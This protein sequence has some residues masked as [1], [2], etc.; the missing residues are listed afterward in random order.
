MDDTTNTDRVKSEVDEDQDA[1]Q[2]AH[3]TS[4]VG[5]MEPLL[6][7][8]LPAQF[9][10]CS[11]RNSGKSTLVASL[12][13]QWLKM[14]R[15]DGHSIIVFSATAAHNSE[16]SWLPPENVRHGWDE[17]LC[18]KI[19]QWQKR[20]LALKKKQATRAGIGVKL[21][22][23]ALVL[24]DIVGTKSLDIAHS[25]VI[26]WLYCSGR[27]IKCST[28][29]CSQLGRVICNPTIRSQ[30]DYVLTS[31]LASDQLDSVWRITSGLSWKEFL[32]KVHALDD[33][34]FI[35]Y[36]SV[37]A[38]GNRWHEMKAPLAPKF[39]IEYKNHKA[40]KPDK[41]KDGSKKC[42]S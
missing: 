17:E 20:R 33:Y 14:G 13:Y 22:G 8:K 25:P 37:I 12:L 42:D 11:R 36:D 4:D 38:K 41:K 5:G 1:E 15:F 7:A 40:K 34:K 26:R 19:I 23:L 10:V 6:N 31:S 27:H 35:L 29:L 24:D 16:Y 2:P 32:A 30:S 28:L 9:L 18:R 3:E 39:R 21:P